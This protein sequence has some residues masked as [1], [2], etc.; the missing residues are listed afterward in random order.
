M[1][2]DR[3]G[4]SDS[5]PQRSV[6][7]PRRGLLAALA[8]AIALAAAWQFVNPLFGVPQRLAALEREWG[9]ETYQ[10][11]RSLYQKLS[12]AVA[13]FL[14]AGDAAL[15][16]V[17]NLAIDVPFDGMRRIYA[18][19]EQALTI[20][21]L[22]QSDDD[23]VNGSI[24]VAD[25][26]IPIRLRL[27]G[28][29]VD[30]LI[31]RKWSF[32]IHTRRDDQFMGLRR[33]S[34]QGPNT[35]AFQA[36]RLFFETVR[37]LGVLAPRYS[38]ANVTL[39][40]EALGLMAV[41]ESPAKELLEH[42]GRKDGVIIRFDESWV[43]RAKDS[44]T[45]SSVGFE[46]AFD[47]YL[48]APIDAFQSGRVA[49]NPALHAQNEIAT[50]LLRGFVEGHLP[51]SEV[52]DVEQLGALL[53]AA[54]VFGSW[55]VVR[56]HN[57]RF[58]LNPLSLRLE[59]VAYDANLQTAFRDDRSIF[60]VSP[61]ARDMLADASV[62]A[63]YQRSVR[64]LSAQID[65]GELIDFIRADEEPVLKILRSEFRMLDAYPVEYLGRRVGS[66]LSRLANPQQWEQSTLIDRPHE[67]SVYP[68][69][70]HAS[71]LHGGDNDSLE[72]SNAIPWIVNVMRVE[73]MQPDGSVVTALRSGELPLTLGPR[74]IGSRAPTHVIDLTQRP[75]DVAQ[76]TVTVGMPER[77]WLQRM[78]VRT[79]F[80]ALR[81]SPAPDDTLE[82]QLSTH[83]YLLFDDANATVSIRQGTWDVVEPIILPRDV[84]LNVSAGTTLRFSE[85]SSMIVRGPVTMHGTPE[86][87]IH[88]M[89]ATDAGWPGFAVLEA[90]GRSSIS[91]I[92]ISSIRGVANGRWSLTGGVAFYKS[93]VEI[94]DSTI[95]DSRGEDAL[96]I[97]HSNF[98][99]R[100]VNIERTAADA[101]DADFSQGQI[102][103][104]S[105]TDIRGDAV[106]VSGSNI[107]VEGTSFERILDK[108]LSVG[109]ASEMRATALLIRD[110]GS[111]AAV[112][113]GSELAM[114]DS[115]I[116]AASFAAIAAFIK[117]AEYG[118]AYVTA[119]NIEIDATETPALAQTHSSISLNGAAIPTQDLDVDALYESVMRPEFAR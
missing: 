71:H 57:M 78:T 46:G 3:P 32:R 92:D 89:P 94:R 80:P 6:N 50:G 84:S 107:S 22:I 70:I 14:R 8:I 36:E 54:D 51:A 49:G 68:V 24:R 88:L 20:G 55:H 75:T 43:W 118:P 87:R 105:F 48:N 106:D 28:D 29:W 108:A 81:H 97:V 15:A 4:E 69:L 47:S 62:F 61:L 9:V 90:N 31:G 33:F 110:T 17:P 73:W 56:W 79:S 37:R 11:D 12:I 23:M 111:G 77:N 2:I 42:S 91:N 25:R 63:A 26:T 66:L 59:P 5:S 95:R 83:P 53:A 39:N 38:F 27:K 119:N 10:D 18:K 52:F 45:R 74:A 65:S 115:T 72:V 19:R 16:N 60:S 58:Y 35:R 76:L 99:M 96:N 41:E 102:L 112:K 40:G 86:S 13:S 93:D 1:K 21:N 100:N 34:I 114:N 30:H 85:D 104:G 103:G 82:H 116:I 98:S 117:K 113:D 7:R 44:L 64:E 101:I 109:E 67:R